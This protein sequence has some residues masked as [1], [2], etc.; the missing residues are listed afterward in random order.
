MRDKPD[1]WIFALDHDP[2]TY[3]RK[4]C[5]WIA[6]AFL[7]QKQSA[8]PACRNCSTV[9]ESKDNDPVCGH[10]WDLFMD[11]LQM[12]LQGEEIT[13]AERWLV[14]AGLTVQKHASRATSDP[15]AWVRQRSQLDSKRAS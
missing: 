5:V 1:S 14:R 7:E 12:N 4:A 10:C 3:T 8:P 9:F 2:L 13:V 15:G 11:L 6:S